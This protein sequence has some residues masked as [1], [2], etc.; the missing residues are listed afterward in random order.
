MFLI[1]I[2]S[3][4]VFI[5][6]ILWDVLLFAPDWFVILMFLVSVILFNLYFYLKHG[7]Y[8][9]TINKT[10]KAKAKAK[11]RLTPDAILQRRM[12]TIIGIVL[13][14]LYVAVAGVTQIIKIGA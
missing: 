9:N 8:V 7:P 13:V 4:I 1:L 2:L 5:G 14:T 10:A 11:A 6:F 3:T 12:M